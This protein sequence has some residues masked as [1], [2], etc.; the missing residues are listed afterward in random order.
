MA[1]A[2]GEAI[3]EC[4]LGSESFTLKRGRVVAVKKEGGYKCSDSPRSPRR[5]LEKLQYTLATLLLPTQTFTH[6]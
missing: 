1:T 3:K 6:H 2:V 5:R 4:P